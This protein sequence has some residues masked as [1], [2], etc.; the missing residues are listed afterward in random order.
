MMTQPQLS[1]SEV[2]L[3]EG[4]SPDMLAPLQAASRA[5]SL[6][7]REFLFKQGDKGRDM[8]I[9]ISGEL[10]VWK[11]NG[12]EVELAHLGP[13]EVVGE[14][15][16][17]DGKRRDAHVQALQPTQL[18]AISRED[19]FR[20]LGNY[21]GMATHM[22]VLLSQRMRA[23]NARQMNFYS[24]YALPGRLATALLLCAAPSYEI[25]GFAD[26]RA[27]MAFSLAVEEA[28]L[29]GLMSDWQAQG[30]IHV[31]G[32]HLTIQVPSALEA[33]TH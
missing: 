2:P 6:E 22:M 12:H 8:F 7:R 27:R 13:K 10:R 30:L 18:L 4:V 28:E 33:L 1:L 5:V 31:D 3:F 19:F 16:L 23:N 25:S 9:I 15:E 11:E 21:P 26:K 20:H 32:D 17:I 29:E 24:Q 14:M